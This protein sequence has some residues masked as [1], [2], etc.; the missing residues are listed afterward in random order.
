[1]TTLVLSLL[2]ILEP[3]AAGRPASSSPSAA[4]PTIDWPEFFASVG[5]RGLVFSDR[6]KA[7]EGQRVRLR[8]C[9]VLRPEWSEG[10]LLT[11]FPFAES[12]PND[13]EDV[14]DIPCDAV[15]VVWRRG[16][17]VPS[18]PER[19]TVEGTLRLG[20]RTVSSQRV[21]ILL[22]DATPAVPPGR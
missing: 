11:R 5:T 10:L 16:I 21:A 15:G 2:L 8:G 12:D 18:V 7:L 20:N 17:A 4:P 9:S 1:M 22:E 6:L 14:L 13:P 3:G 19:P